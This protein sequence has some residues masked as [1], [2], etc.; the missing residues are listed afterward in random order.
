VF[1]GR[2]RK[3]T[4]KWVTLDA[5][6]PGSLQLLKWVP[7]EDRP[8]DTDFPRFPNLIPALKLE[9]QTH[10]TPSLAAGEAITG[11]L[12]PE[13]ATA[14]AA[15]AASA[16]IPPVSAEPAL[17]SGGG[18]PD[19][20]ASNG[21]VGQKVKEAAIQANGG[22]LGAPVDAPAQEAPTHEA[23]ADEAE[24]MLVDEVVAADRRGNEPET[25]ATADQHMV[26]ASASKDAER[27]CEAGDKEGTPVAAVDA[28][29]GA[30]GGDQAM[31]DLQPNSTRPPVAQPS[32]IPEGAD[33]QQAQ[34][35]SNPPAK[36][37]PEE[38][39]MEEAAQ[40]PDDA[41]EKAEEPS[42]AAGNPPEGVSEKGGI[43]RDEAPTQPGN[44]TGQK[45]EEPSDP[46]ANPPE[47]P[48]EVPPST[49]EVPSAT[50]EG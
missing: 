18:V 43:P 36:E 13:A 39:P 15:A 29:E 50:G 34:H 10:T 19:G 24:P 23:A 2:V 6:A 12:S 31:E 22:G 30:A 27:D 4:K 5:P 35:P 11:A 38:V 8:E 49:E 47:V 3:W 1:T 17:E 25:G 28:V 44:A 7:T 21:E 41:G 32:Q 20:G 48:K 46:A 14:S 42:V 33:G 16:A 45:A 40:P 9:Q 26:E 37:G